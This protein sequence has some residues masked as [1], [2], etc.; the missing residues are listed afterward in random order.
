[1]AQAAA[2]LLADG[3][4]LLPPAF[5]PAFRNP[6][7]RCS[8]D[9]TATSTSA[10]S[11]TSAAS[12]SAASASASASP[13]AEL[14]CLPAAHVLGVSKCGT[15]DLHS[16]LSRAS[17]HLLPSANKGPHF[18]DEHHTFASYLRLYGRSARK[19]A[20]A[21]A[22]RR[23]VDILVDASSNT[24]SYSGVG[25]RGA[26]APQVVLLPH[27]L[28]WLQPQLRMVIMLREPGA[29]YFSAYWYY[30]KRYGIYRAFGPLSAASFDRMARHE[31]ARFEACAARHAERRCARTQFDGAQQLVKGLYAAFLPDW[32]GAF[33]PEQFLTLRLEDYEA[34]PAPHLRATL[35]FLGLPS[36]SPQR[37]QRMLA[38][39]RAN[40]RQAGGAALLPATAAF[41]RAF[42][43]PYNAQLAYWLGDDRWLWEDVHAAQP[44]ASNATRE[45][46]R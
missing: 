1:M 21:T 35:S 28:A 45:W 3:H 19:L 4:S 17:T 12:A 32:L 23:A 44:A 7:W 18:W 36:P 22:A 43:A 9:A 26:R 29:R 31:A 30:H 25:V 41:L 24:F 11:A 5:N 16:R 27:V 6:C 33:P 42:Y 39:P 40:R 46:G 14:C 13:G 2:R 20:A 37:W 15:T 8:L 38:Q 34:S 10:T